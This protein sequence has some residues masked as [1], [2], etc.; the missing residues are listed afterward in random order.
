MPALSGQVITTI[1]DASGNPAVTVTWFWDPL[2]GLLRNNPAAWT[3]P[4]G[5]V[6]PAGTGALIADNQ[7]GWPVRMRI[8][9]EVGNLLRRVLLPVGGRAVK[10]LA[11]TLAP[12]P[13]GPYL[14]YTDL[15]GLSFDLA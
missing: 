3:A 2:T 14:L 8:E 9:D 5:T 1:T 7:M 6:Y 10:A 13:D 4:D 12:P 11:L 15:N